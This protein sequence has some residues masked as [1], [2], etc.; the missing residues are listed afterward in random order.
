MRYF[1]LVFFL[2]VVMPLRAQLIMHRSDGVHVYHPIDSIKLLLREDRII[3][4][5]ERIQGSPPI[6][7]SS[8]LMLQDKM[9]SLISFTEEFPLITY[10][11]SILLDSIGLYQ[12]PDLYLVTS[13]KTTTCEKQF[14]NYIQHP[15]YYD[16]KT[17]DD[18]L[19]VTR[20]ITQ[21]YI[22]DS[23]ADQVTYRYGEFGSE[24]VTYIEQ[25]KRMYKYDGK[26]RLRKIIFKTRDK[27]KWSIMATWIITYLK[28]DPKHRAKV[29]S[30][31]E[32]YK[33][34]PN[35]RYKYKD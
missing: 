21:G 3:S 29:F 4:V 9:V 32:K 12:N 25:F 7:E 33:Y 35:K 13:E 18:T 14:F 16:T 17:E 5:R 20:I 2:N 28:N 23:V 8:I 1:I 22:L 10:V 27:K 30:F 6:K 26:K 11:D 15:P 24:S 31:Y 19:F 34:D